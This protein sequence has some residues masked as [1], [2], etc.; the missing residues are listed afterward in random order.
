MAKMTAKKALLTSILSLL[1]C[2]TMLV[3]T[4]FA[5]FTDSVTSGT[6]KIIA[7]N[8]DVNA[9]FYAGDKTT[10]EEIE[11]DTLNWLPVQNSESIFSQ[12][13]WEPGHTEIAYLKIVNEGTLAFKYTVNV[14]PINEI[15]G[16]NVAG[17]A[18]K[19]SNY[20]AFAVTAPSETYTAY[21]RTTARAAIDSSVITA[22]VNGESTS[23]TAIQSNVSRTDK[24]LLAGKTEYIAVIVYMPEEVGNVANY[25]KGTTAPEIDLG[26]SI[27]AAQYTK[28]EDS[29]GYDYDESANN[30][31]NDVIEY[32]YFPQVVQSAQ[33][34][35]SATEGKAEK[36]GEDAN[37]TEDAV[38]NTI[39]I[40]SAAKVDNVVTN[41]SA[42]SVTISNESIAFDEGSS[43]ATVTLNVVKNDEGV[44]ASVIAV[45]DTDKQETT[46]YDV[47]L[48][49]VGGD[50]EKDANDDTKY[51]QLITVSM[52]IGK[53][54]TGLSLYH[55]GNEMV[56]KSSLEA[57]TLAD[58]YYYDSAS[59]FVTM[60]VD[61]LSPFTAV[62]DAPVASI[63][64]VAYYSLAEAVKDVAANGT[65]EILRDITLSEDISINKEFVISLNGN[66][67]DVARLVPYGTNQYKVTKIDEKIYC[68]EFGVVEVVGVKEYNSFAKA[69]ANVPE[70][71]TIKLKQDVYSVDGYE[72]NKSFTLDTN[73]KTFTV[74]T[75]SNVNNRAFKVTSGTFTVYGGGTVDALSENGNGCYGAFRAEIG[76][77]LVLSN[78]TLKNYRTNGLNVKLL[79]ATATLNN[80][81]I[82][83]VYGGGIEVT[84]S[85]LGNNSQKGFAT[86]TDCT[87]TQATYGDWC[88]TT[89]SVSGGS[90]LVVNSGSYTSEN[91]ALYVFSSGGEIE[92]K[93]GTFNGN[94]TFGNKTGVAIVAEIDTGTF[95]GYAG[96]F[97]IT[98]GTFNGD[99]AITSPA[100]MSITGGT[101]SNSPL[102]Y[103]D[104]DN[105][106]LVID[107]SNFSHYT[108]TEKA[109]QA[110]IAE[111]LK[112]NYAV[113][114]YDGGVLYAYYYDGD[115]YIRDASKYTGTSFTIPSYVTGLSQASFGGNNTIKTLTFTS[116]L[117]STYKAFEGNSSIEFIDFG[118]MTS[119]PNR[120]FYGCTGIKNLV[121]PATVNR[122]EDYAFYGNGSIEY[123]VAR[124]LEYVGY[125]AFDSA[126][127]LKILDIGG[128]NVAIMGWAGRGVHSIEKIIIRGANATVNLD[129]A[130]SGQTKGGYVFNK[131]GQT[132]NNGYMDGVEMYFANDT[133]AAQ[134][135]SELGTQGGIRKGIVSV[136]DADE[137]NAAL[138]DGN[139]AL[140]ANDISVV[141][142]ITAPYGNKLAI[143]QSNGG[144]IDGNGH[145]LTVSGSGDVYGI[146][147]KGGLIEN[148][149]INGAFR[150]I[151]TMYP[152]K[153]LTLY[154][155]VSG[156]NEVVYALNT[157]EHGKVNLYAIDCSFYG[158][159]SYAGLDSVTFY[160]CNFGQ[161]NVYLN[162]IGRLVKPYVNTTFEDCTFIRG[163][164]LDLSS[165]DSNQ[166]VI[167]ADCY[168]NATDITA[169]NVTDV[170]TAVDEDDITGTATIYFELPSGRTLAD[171]VVFE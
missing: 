44:P 165:L 159:T 90:R 157:A 138:A 113:Y 168:A 55:N 2:V 7:G 139:L 54:K 125:K 62:Y 21:T 30:A 116:Q 79:G 80:V 114:V 70:N 153:D 53:G 67:V 41:E 104:L 170:M 101:Y 51:A 136:S 93:G 133:V 6:N 81:K 50:F 69:L 166:K 43:V 164:Y 40:N 23:L 34:K 64:T 82:D 71:G 17:E 109:D 144:I 141:A 89:L 31:G 151:I 163:L 120:M 3:G 15:G 11:A 130:P 107:D 145:T 36:D 48:E 117:S 124:D 147:T 76:T 111:I 150:G 103:V 58:E 73:G 72:I 8:L 152:D 29:F 78:I 45:V 49:V 47:D 155:V 52:Y 27:Y 110:A 60:K 20:L 156:G 63:G 35:K 123:I 10:A 171:C 18:F 160:H 57:V 131:I 24:A 38:E 137:L 56:G 75:G 61:H 142:E 108:V 68:E 9:Y 26:I 85:S 95:P 148:V 5:W 96:G 167:I 146:M 99:Y 102:N 74:E 22:A 13:L 132:N 42:A 94:A 134:F 100:Y 118:N 14:S 33:L 140:F 59:G 143:E 77:E 169:E 154:N 119:I 32:N 106:M 16:V 135:V 122:I 83:S 39:T 91:Y 37:V 98:G 1:V 105:Y 128:E 25:K 28:E 88:S 65:I 4:T 121:I 126:S 46:N 115:V 127:A 149:T 161:G 162:C 19:L 112:T 92:V 86:L 97:R 12:D 87:F 66:T 129:Y 158:W 84:E